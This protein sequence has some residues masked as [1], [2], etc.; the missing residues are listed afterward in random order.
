MSKPWRPDSDASWLS[1]A[2]YHALSPAE[3]RLLW[4]QRQALG[5]HERRFRPTPARYRKG[6]FARQ[7]LIWMAVVAAFVAV[8]Q[9]DF[10]QPL[11]GG[12]A[13]VATP[14]A[15]PATRAS[16]A[17]C[18]WGGGYNCVVDGDTLYLEGQKIRMAGIDAPETHDYG[19]EFELAL[20]EQ[21]A[22]R[23]QALVSSAQ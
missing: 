1:P 15:G 19:C 11:F 21:A 22:A 23:L 18:K 12:T 16:F 14:V 17:A 13:V 5:K 4:R 3:K 2:A 7:R 20:G 6:Y 8:S 10:M 9:Q